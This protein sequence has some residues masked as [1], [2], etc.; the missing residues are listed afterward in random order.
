MR[1]SVARRQIIH[2]GMKRTAVALLMVAAVAAAAGG[3]TVDSRVVAASSAQKRS[4]EDVVLGRSAD[5][6]GRLVK[7]SDLPVACSE[8]NV[9]GGCAP[10]ILPDGR[11]FSLV[12]HDEFDGDSLDETKWSAVALSPSSVA[13]FAVA[14]R[15]RQ[16]LR[17]KFC[18]KHGMSANHHERR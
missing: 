2:N 13:R 4:A 12:W 16:C 11:T 15:L 5:K 7:L 10:S 8:T 6:K 3:R 17:R 14:E 9:V 1:K 18:S